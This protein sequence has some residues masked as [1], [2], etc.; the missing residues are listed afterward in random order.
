[1]TSELEQLLTAIKSTTT[2]LMKFAVIIR[3]SPTRDDYLKAATRYNYD[4]SF[5]V[6]YT[7]HVREQ[8]GSTIG[9]REWLIER[10]ETAITRRRQYLTYRRDHHDKLSRTWDRDDDNAGLEDQREHTIAFTTATEY[11][12]N[13]LLKD[14]LKKSE[15][16]EDSLGTMTSYENT[17][18]GEVGLHRSVPPPPALA[19]ESVPFEYGEAFQCPYCYT[20]QVV[21]DRQAWK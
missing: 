19:F 1:M 20:E 17:I 5:N 2:S 15:R 11:L 10:M 16:T 3:K 18:F 6:F 4:F 14:E 9:N 12:E 13:D 8:Y 21:R 7:S